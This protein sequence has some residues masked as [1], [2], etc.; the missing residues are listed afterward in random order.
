MTSGST[1]RLRRF[2]TISMPGLLLCSLM[3]PRLSLAFELDRSVDGPRDREQVAVLA[4]DL[5]ALDAQGLIGPP[6][7]KR[8]LS[9]E[10]C[11]PANDARVAEVRGIDPSAH[12]FPVSPGRIGCG[13]DQ[14]LVIGHTHQPGFTSILKRLADLPYVERIEPSDFE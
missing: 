9:Y 4:I 8:A 13:S 14:V 11:I 6:N 12:I 10:F 2:P 5:S 1:H 7:G 3:L